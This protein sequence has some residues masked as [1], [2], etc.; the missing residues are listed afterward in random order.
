[1]GDQA[2]STQ[3][4]ETIQDL[5]SI[6]LMQRAHREKVRGSYSVP[7]PLSQLFQLHL[8]ALVI[9]LGPDLLTTHWDWEGLR[10]CHLELLKFERGTE[11]L[12][13]STG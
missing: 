3:G 8:Y 2:F 11:L 13:N 10:D 4:L 7:S 12:G 6:L 9:E 5:N 1:M